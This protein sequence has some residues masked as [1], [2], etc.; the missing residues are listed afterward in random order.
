M[1]KDFDSRVSF[2][3]ILY[4][5][6]LVFKTCVFSFL[7]ESLFYYKSIKITTCIFNYW[8][9]STSPFPSWDEH[10]CLHRMFLKLFVLTLSE[11]YM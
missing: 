10:K 9:Y 2:C 7:L 4:I 5:V 3:Q 8:R 6:K 1:L 11:L